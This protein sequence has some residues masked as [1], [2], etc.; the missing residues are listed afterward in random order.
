[1]YKKKRGWYN[2][3][4]IYVYK[5]YKCIHFFWGNMNR[6]SS[7]V[8]HWRYI[9]SLWLILLIEIGVLMPSTNNSTLIYSKWNEK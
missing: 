7:Y 5:I 6:L 1:M 3:H 8:N 4:I 2:V 9:W